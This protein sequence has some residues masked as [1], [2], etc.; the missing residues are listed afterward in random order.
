V[1]RG[2]LVAALLVLALAP[3]ARAE[4]WVG[5]VYLDDVVVVAA[6]DT[7][8]WGPG[9]AITGPGHVEVWGSLVVEGDPAHRA[10][11]AVPVLLLGNGTSRVEHA[12][13][14]G[15]HG[16]AI[17]VS[18]G[19][20]EAHDVAFEA[21][22]EGLV[23]A[24]DSRVDLRDASFRGNAGPALVVQGSPRVSLS[25]GLVE[26]NGRG[27]EVSSAASLL[28]EDS[29]LRGDAPL[30]DVAWDGGPLNASFARN[31]LSALQ[32]GGGPLVAI[33]AASGEEPA[34]ALSFSG[35][36]LHAATVGVLVEGPGPAFESRNDTLDA[37][38]VGLSLRGG[39]ARLVGTTL[40]NVR[41]V[42]GSES[43]A[44]TLDNV[45]YLRAA[46]ATVPQGAPAAFPWATLGLGAVALALAGLIVAQPLAKR[47][48]ARAAPPA[49]EAPA[50]RSLPALTPQE[51]RILRDLA[52]HPGSAQASAAA[53][54]GMTRQ[55]LHY[56]VKKLEARGLVVKEAQGRETRCRVP[57]DV[58]AGLPP[59]DAADT[60]SE[61]KG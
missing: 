29:T 51:L 9:V 41:D 59:P 55:A 60:R 38:A 40:G 30:V 8:E 22:R 17:A 21:N 34:P 44:L 5:A 3:G 43:G 58:A 7:L 54:L 26:A 37:N 4:P 48:R 12:R 56:H 52:A 14:W 18:H 35:N 23:V 61:E 47:R 31:D 42:E 33:H 1:P 49:P 15:S 27:I 16:A 25:R 50:P 6:N 24:N 13:F 53:R 11:V 36:R 46:A 10:E 39:T 28:V 2:W 45:T 32:A 57:D 20:L 19:A